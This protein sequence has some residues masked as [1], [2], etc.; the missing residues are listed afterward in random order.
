MNLINLRKEA[1]LLLANEE[2][3]KMLKHVLTL[4]GEEVA[5]LDREDVFTQLAYADFSPTRE[6]WVI[7]S[8]VYQNNKTILPLLPVINELCKL[9]EIEIFSAMNDGVFCV[10]VDGE[11]FT[12][13]F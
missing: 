12:F 10:E 2:Q 4:L 11:M 7:R 8:I 6:K 1:I 3:Y 13:Q 5:G 9:N